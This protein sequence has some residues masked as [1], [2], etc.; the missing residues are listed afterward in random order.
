M[1]N[2]YNLIFLLML[3]L[4]ATGRAEVQISAAVDKQTAYQNEEIHLSVR[5]AGSVKNLQAP[6]LPV[7]NAFD[8][9]YSGRASHFSFINGRTQS[10][11]EFSYVLVPKATG[12]FNLESI[13][14]VIEG[15]VYRTQPIQIQILGQ[16]APT[17]VTPTRSRPQASRVQSPVPVTPISPRQAPGI[18]PAAQS[19]PSQDDDQNI[20]LRVQP[21]KRQVYSNEQILLTYSLLTR[22]DT[23]YEG[24]HD[25]PEMSG[26]WVEEFPM[27]RDI[28]KQTELINGRKYLRADIK[29]FALFPTS[30]GKYIIKPGSIKASIQ[31]EQRPT[32]FLDEFFNDSFF[33]NSG[34]FSRRVDKILGTEPIT[35]I[36]KP[37]PNRGK[38]EQFNGAVGQFRIASS[39]DRRVVDQ[40]VPIT[41]TIVIEGEGNIETLTHP[42]L[43]DLEEVKIYDSDTK[44]E[45][46]K[47][48]GLIA[49]KK[50]FEIILIPKQAGVLDIPSLSFSYFDPRSEKYVTIKTDS[51]QI[52]VNPSNALLPELPRSLEDTD[53]SVQKEVKVVGRDIRYIHEN[54]RIKQSG[55]RWYH[56]FLLAINFLLTVVLMGIIWQL[57]QAQVWSANQGLMRERFA[58]KSAGKTL[59]KLR[60][61][62]RQKSDEAHQLFFEE[63]ERV[64]N[65]Y[66]ADKL[67]LSPHGL[68]IATISEKLFGRQA[69]KEVIDDISKFY[70]TCGMIRYAKGE[71]FESTAHDVLQ[72]LEKILREK[73]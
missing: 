70:E 2:A 13:E 45:F 22:Y 7:M 11:T 24:F 47:S 54:M 28:K 9:F 23:R 72:S 30:P 71:G 10:T 3:I 46:F 25:E 60:K 29:K 67:N 57:Q 34:V 69:S 39:L 33:S 19:G 55:L 56:Q 65:Q 42:P 61:L 64:M 14:V 36:V 59:Q 50:T 5:I 68:T 41:L 26:F 4:P 40:N 35:V 27:E 12:V 16:V 38:P 18:M 17:R 21:N 6:R 73:I 58:K 49:G 66:L 43:P 48:K 1:R 37:L 15:R 63:A 53:I 51:Y 8:S 44:S 62:T 52:Q 32:S 20:F 31:I